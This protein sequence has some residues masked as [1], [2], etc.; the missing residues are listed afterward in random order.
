MLRPGRSE[1]DHDH[2]DIACD[3]CQ[4]YAAV[5]SG[6]DGWKRRPNRALLSSQI[7]NTSVTTCCVRLVGSR[8]NEATTTTYTSGVVTLIGLMT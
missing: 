7:A 1:I 3:I 5:R 4:E 8:G 6:W 2:I